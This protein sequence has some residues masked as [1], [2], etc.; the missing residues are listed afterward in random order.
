[1]VA[2]AFGK[3]GWVERI[4][5]ATLKISDLSLLETAI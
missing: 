5:N 2:D 3:V 1:M 4:S